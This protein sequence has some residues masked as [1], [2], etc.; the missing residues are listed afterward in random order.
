MTI[1]VGVDIGGT[2]TDFALIDEAA[3]H[4]WSHKTLTTPEDPSRAV[5]DGLSELLA[6]T[7]D[8]ISDIAVLAHGTT[9]ITNAVIE[10]KGAVT[11][12]LVTEGFA[13]VIDIA[14]ETRYEIF[15]LRLHY[16]EPVVPRPR[17]IEIAERI[18]RNGSVEKKLSEQAIVDGVSTLIKKHNIR[19][20]G[21]CFLNS[22]RNPENEVRAGEIIKS[23]F[24]DLFVSVSS[25]V[26]NSIKE[27]ERWTTTLI[28]AYT[29]PLIDTY[30]LG[31]ET[32]LNSR[33][34]KGSIRIMTS[35]GGSYDPALARQF[36]V[37][38]IESGPAAGILMT[39]ELA[40]KEGLK[41]VLAFDMGGT[42]AKGAFIRDGRPIKKYEMEI[43]REHHFRP[44]SGLPVRVPV[45]D[46]IEIGSG[47]GSIAHVDRRGLVNVGPTSASSKPGPA[48]YALGGK[49][50]T[51]TDAHLVL[52][53]LDSGYFLGG[54]MELDTSLAA[55]VLTESICRK[56]D[57]SRVE[58]AAAGIR[59]IAA[60]DVAA[61][62]RTHAA[63]L[64]LDVRKSTLVA[65][66]GS[67]P[68]M[69]T[70]VARK[71]RI[72]D[73]LFPAGSGVFSAIGL[74]SSPASFESS[75]TFRVRVSAL[76]DQTIDEVFA[77]LQHEAK[78]A[79]SGMAVAPDGIQFEHMLE[80]RY[81]GQ[82]H[83]VRIA[84]PE[85]AASGQW[86]D[87]IK[88][89]FEKE[90]AVTFAVSPP[91]GEAEV[92]DWRVVATESRIKIPSSSVRPSGGV[93]YPTGGARRIW[94]GTQFIECRK[95]SRYDL[96]PGETLDG[97]LLIQEVESTCVLLS[98]D[99][100]KVLE[101]GHIHVQVGT[102]S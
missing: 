42:T 66:G 92:T 49:Q 39:A 81:A 82:G 35:S 9:L 48:C 84:L 93:N 77:S 32:E 95:L 68:I 10:R 79:L 33:G 29:Q 3:E 44:G 1:R 45:V 63:E 28:N 97:P 87:R 64:G 40:N 53:Y 83:Q 67:G 36:P 38:L 8:K 65:F 102:G 17:R 4:T 61:A 30:L 78:S 89:A 52:G 5:V 62:F 26:A 18:S 27:Y 37:R 80:L 20:V 23:H 31:L 96:R 91:E 70:L 86:R 69:A 74:L 90:Y 57:T 58:G 101:Q 7:G 34:F 54:R 14:R 85:K 55:E 71:L 51:L 73:V 88:A 94:D 76:D 75:R 59:Q 50:P 25:A 56:I 72:K 13:D 60:E 99:R 41:D 98:G 47:G 22:F 100:G 46:M 19:S 11:G 43:A 21:V 12:M 24:P 6:V 2:F 16:A 15:D